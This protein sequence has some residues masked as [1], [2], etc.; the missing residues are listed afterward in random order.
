MFGCHAVASV[1]YD[2]AQVVTQHIVEDDQLRLIALRS[3]GGHPIVTLEGNRRVAHL[4]RFMGMDSLVLWQTVADTQ[5][6]LIAALHREY[7]TATTVTVYS[8]LMHPTAGRTITRDGYA[9]SQPELLGTCLVFEVCVCTPDH[10]FPIK[11][12]P[13]SDPRMVS[14]FQSVPTPEILVEATFDSEFVQRLCEILVERQ[15]R[16]EGAVIH[17]T[18]PNGRV[19]GWK[20]RTGRTETGQVHH[21]F[22]ND[23]GEDEPD[24]LDAPDA[25]DAPDPERRKMVAALMKMFLDTASPEA[26]ERAKGRSDALSKGEGN[27]PARRTGPAAKPSRREVA[28]D[29][30]AVDAIWCKVLTH[31]DYATAHANVKGDAV[32]TENVRAQMLRAFAEQAIKDQAMSLLIPDRSA[33]RDATTKNIE[34]TTRNLSVFMRR[35]VRA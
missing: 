26:I 8:E 33:L 11:L 4:G 27:R 23:A 25:P 32:A 13:S 16:D 3:H 18:L 10:A 28:L 5:S 31:Y 17:L 6:A 12:R 35:H 9:K 7:P 2:G 19:R 22:F 29:Y 14:L 21:L 1:K 34:G 24:A 15:A 20:L 30:A